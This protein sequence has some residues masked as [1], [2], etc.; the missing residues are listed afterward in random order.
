MTYVPVTS[1]DIKTRETSSRK[2]K[3][4]ISFRLPKETL[5]NNSSAVN[6]YFSGSSYKKSWKNEKDGKTLIIT[7]TKDNFPICAPSHE[8]CFTHQI[9]EAHTG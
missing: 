2:L 5:E 9:R 1:I 3:R 4:T 7:F 6:S 8:R